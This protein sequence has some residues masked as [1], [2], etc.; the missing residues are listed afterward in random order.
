MGTLILCHPD[1]CASA[2]LSGGSWQTLLPLNN[3]KS[4]PLGV[5]ARSTNTATDSTEIQIDLMSDRSAKILALCGH[6]MGAI[7]KYRVRV[8]DLSDYSS[9][10]YDS[11]WLDVWP[12]SWSTKSLDW[13]SDGWWEGRVSDDDLAGYTANLIHV[14]PQEIYARY[15]KLMID[16]IGNRDGHVQAGRLVVAQT[17][18]PDVNMDWGSKLGH[19]TDTQSETALDGARYFDVRPVRRTFSCQLS[20]LSN[21]EAYGGILD[22]QRK[23][24]VNGDMFVVTSLEDGTNLLRRNFLATFRQLNAIEAPYLNAHSVALEFTEVL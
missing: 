6:N 15:W 8:S 17:W 12:A 13:E 18:M 2:T 24:G 4:G 7:A 21:D 14:L 1:R 11:G 5:V 23:L 16:D 20:W 19:E 10:I 3:L 9:Y 22:M